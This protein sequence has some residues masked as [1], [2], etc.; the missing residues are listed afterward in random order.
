MAKNMA[1]KAPCSKVLASVYRKEIAT[2][3]CWV[4]K[5]SNKQLVMLTPAAIEQRKQKLDQ[6]NAW[7]AAKGTTRCGKWAKQLQT[8]TN[9]IK[10]DTT[11]L[12]ATTQQI[13][14]RTTATHTEVQQLRKE[15]QEYA[16][17]VQVNTQP[18]PNMIRIVTEMTG[19]CVP[20]KI[21]NAILKSQGVSCPGSKQDKAAF[22][23]EH[24]KGREKELRDLILENKN[25]HAQGLPVTDAEK[26]RMK[27]HKQASEASNARKSPPED[28]S[29]Y[30]SSSSSSSYSS[31][32]ENKT[33]TPKE[34]P[35]VNQAP[36]PVQ[37]FSE[38]LQKRN[39]TSDT[40]GQPSKKRKEEVSKKKVDD[41]EKPSDPVKDDLKTV[42]D[43]A[44]VASAP[45][46]AEDE[47]SEYSYYSDSDEDD[48]DEKKL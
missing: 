41:T 13:D 44:P 18:A 32:S 31:D 21:M 19:P 2:G 25:L 37:G 7:M 11:Q 38:A 8:T 36:E 27:K 33:P 15:V 26:K 39:A 45:S 12:V 47:T 16:K 17:M 6:Y 9:A 23:G 22:L 14:K 3:N 48:N 29:S 1:E 24:F 30:S 5:G 40:E 35:G 43:A 4:G 42:E 10:E 34:T 46:K 20:V 28:S